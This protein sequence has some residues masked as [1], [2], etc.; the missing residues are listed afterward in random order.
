M[1]KSILLIILLIFL[2]PLVSGCS[3]ADSLN[4]S[5]AIED[6]RLQEQL[7]NELKQQNIEVK[8]D[9]RRAVLFASEDRKK[10]HAIAFKIMGRD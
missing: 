3:A 8:V 1:R 7:I 4:E 9:E 6:E 10:V 5:F 2:A